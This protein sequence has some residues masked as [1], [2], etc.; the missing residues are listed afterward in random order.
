M[1]RRRR[2]RRHAR[3]LSAL[4]NDDLIKEKYRGIRPASGYPATPDHTEK[5]TIWELLDAEAN[6]G[7]ALT[8]NFAMTPGSCVS[9]LYFGHPDAK[10]T[11]VGPLNKDQFEDYSARKAQSLEATERWLAP[12]RGY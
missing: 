2:R 3:F 5:A 12:N 8:E 7:A 1:R 10:Y 11:L 6:T 4:T 9:G